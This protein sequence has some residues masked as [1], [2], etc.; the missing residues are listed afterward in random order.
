[1]FY[2]I[3]EKKN[4]FLEYKNKKSEKPKNSR[5]KNAFLLYKNK[6]AKESKNWDY[7]M[8]LVKLWQ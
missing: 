3:L 1:M 8:V 5:K 4:A 2:D 6:K 7:S